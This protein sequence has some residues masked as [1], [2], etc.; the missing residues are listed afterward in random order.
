MKVIFALI[1]MLSLAFTIVTAGKD[2]YARSA[3]LSNQKRGLQGIITFYDGASLNNAA[4]YGRGG[5]PK[6]NAKP[7]DLIAAVSMKGESMC[8]KCLKITNKKK[9]VIVKIIDKCAS[10]KPN[11]I[12]L[13]PAAF[14]TLADSDLGV[15][16]ITFEPVS[17]PTNGR[18]PT[19]EKKRS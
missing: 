12:D 19:L 14:N 18:F 8:F 2:W 7:S 15:V 3:N 1:L 4:C 10:C 11:H 17:C 16:K 5:L 9:S 6:Y 13:S